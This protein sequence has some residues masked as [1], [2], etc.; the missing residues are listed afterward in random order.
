MNRQQV[1]QAVG[2]AFGRTSQ[3]ALSERDFDAADGVPGQRTTVLDRKSEVL[4]GLVQGRQVILSVPAVETFTSDGTGG[5]SE[6]FNLSND[7]IDSS[8]VADSVDVLIDDGTSVDRVN[9]DAVDFGAD[10][11]DVTDP[12]TDNTVAV[13]YTAGNQAVAELV[14]QTP[15]DRRGATEVLDEFD[16]SLLHRRDPDKTQV[17]L[18][19]SRPLE[20]V[21]PEDFDLQLRVDAPYTASFE[22]DGSET[23]VPSNAVLSLP[24]KRTRVDIEGLKDAVKQEMIA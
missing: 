20:G 1:I 21:I 6:T 5:N 13:F 8:H 16:P 15:S 7:L 3:G 2:A 17:T 24:R 14:K 23:V 4:V 12:G 18:D 22:Y 10:T 19:F 9:P 11:V